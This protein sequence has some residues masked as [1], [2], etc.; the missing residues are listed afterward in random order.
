MFRIKYFNLPDYVQWDLPEIHKLLKKE[1]GFN[2]KVSDIRYDCLA[3]PHSNFLF[4][5]IAGFSK[6]EFLYANMVRAG[7]LDRTEA[8]KLLS[9]REH[10]GLPDGF[11]SFME[12]IGCPETILND[13]EG[14]STIDFQG[15]RKLIKKLAIRLREMLP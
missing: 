8:L 9:E 13:T 15:R 12:S 6:L 14:R 2:K 4:K 3:T 10:E 1:L 5:R 11:L 7:Y